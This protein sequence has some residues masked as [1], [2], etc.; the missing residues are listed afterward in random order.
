MKK[1]IAHF[2]GSRYVTKSSSRRNKLGLAVFLAACSL[3]YGCDNSGQPAVE[4]APAPAS[5]ASQVAPPV[6]LPKLSAPKLLEVQDA[7]KRVFK[8]AAVL[9]ASRNPNFIAG[10]FNGDVS[11][12]IA[13]VL[14][15][16][17]GKVAEMNEEFP[18]WIL[19]DPFAPDQPR[20]PRPR[21]E[22]ND[23]L[24]AV[25]HG[26]SANDWRDPQATQTYLLKNAVGSGIEVQTAKDVM[27]AYTGKKLPRLHGDVIAERL[28][29]TPGCLYYA[30][31]TYSWYDPKS[32]KGDPETGMFHRGGA[33]RR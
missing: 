5:Q 20:M 8:D 4:E 31:S 24:L 2:L 12:D 9:D 15:V 33:M 32:F 27:A 14:K 18:P 17:S 11:Q 21:V 25:I 16:A 22:E 29:G 7:V 1:R 13:V 10:D 28:R 6:Q 23:V 3:M 30:G 26:Y 19:K